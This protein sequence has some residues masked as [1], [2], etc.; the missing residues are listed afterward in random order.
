MKLLELLI[1][2]TALAEANDVPA[3]A[4]LLNE[5]P[6]MV[7][8][9]E[10]AASMMHDAALDG[11]T[12]L[13]AL[14]VERG[15]DINIPRDP[16][17]PERPIGT[18]A[19]LNHAETIRWL[20]EHGSAINYEWDGGEPYCIPLS[21]VIRDGNLEIVKLLVEAGARLDVLDRRGLTPLSWAINLGKKEI[22][23]YLR[24]K[25]AIEAHDAPGYREPETR[26]PILEYVEENFSRP[27]PLG[28]AAIVPEEVPVFIHVAADGEIACV[29][30]EGMSARAMKVPV[31]G[32]RYQ[33]AELVTYL[34]NWPEDRQLWL[35]P[36]YLWP[37]MWMRRIAQ[38]PFEHNT[39]LGGQTP[40]IANGDPPVP[41]GPGTEMTCWLLLA[42]KE[43]LTRLE[44]ADG[45]E[46]FFYEMV[47]IH[48]AERDYER[49]HG[50]VALLEKLADNKVMGHVNPKRESVV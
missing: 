48:T 17:W 14:L 19:A 26:N 35:E 42:E 30:T 16:E 32:E 31:G 24:S 34:Y 1:Q 18:A 45:R 5:H 22:A 44:M 27:E 20:V 9:H 8:T 41:L 49:E 6:E 23:A 28:W 11:N 29:I 39:W 4:R 25:G 40:I 15:V 33:H 12:A 46:V 38:Y 13:V 37:I 2:F 36:E 7:A 10:C 50:I 21:A 47:P 3:I 43:P